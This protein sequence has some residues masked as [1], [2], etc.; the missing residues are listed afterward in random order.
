MKAATALSRVLSLRGGG[1]PAAGF[2]AD[3][4]AGLRADLPTMAV[5]IEIRD[6]LD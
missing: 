1:V 5:S 3:F 2:W 6:G 4:R